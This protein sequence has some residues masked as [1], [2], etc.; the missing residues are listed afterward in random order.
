[1]TLLRTLPFVGL[2]LV[3][4]VLAHADEDNFGEDEFGGFFD[5][6]EF[7]SIATGSKKLI[8][9]APAV[10]T[11]IRADEIKA[12][13]YRTLSEALESVPGLHVS[14]SSQLYSPKIIIRGISSTF[15]PQTL[16]LVDGVPITSIV[17]GDRHAVWGDFPVNS[18]QRIEV[19]RGPGSALYGADAFSGIINI[20][21]KTADDIDNNQ[22][23]VSIGS[24]N[25]R[26]AW[27]LSK[28]I[29]GDFKLSLT[30]EFITTDGFDALIDTDIQ[31]SIDAL[32]LAPP[33]SYAPGNASLGYKGID[34]RFDVSY[35]DFDLKVG[36]QDRD[37]VGHGQGSAGALD[38]VGRFNSEKFLANLTYN[39]TKTNNWVSDIN[40]SYYRSNQKVE[41]DLLLFPPGAF[42]GAFPEG[43]IGN[44][45]WFERTSVFKSESAYTGFNKNKI[46][47]GFGYK[48]EDLY[49]VKEQKNFDAFL[50]PLGELVDVT[51]SNEV[52]IPESDRSSFFIYVQDEIQIAP[53]WELTAGIR[54]DDYS[55]F[56]STTNP[57]L[58][59]V[60]S[61]SL[62]LNTK[63]LYGRAFR[64]P[65]FAETLVVNNPIALGNP[66]LSPETI[67][68]FEVAFDYAQSNALKYHLNIYQFKV[69]DFINFV[70]DDG[71]P[72]ATAQNI[73]QLKGHGFESEINYR[74]NDDF[75]FSLNLSKQTTTDELVK[76]DLGGAPDYQ[77]YLSSMWNFYPDS[78]LNL[79]S[80]YVGKRARSSLD[81]RDDLDS[82][83]NT[84]ITYHLKNLGPFNLSF[85]I[86]NLFDSDIREPSEGPN[87]T[88]PQV[89]F[90]ND[91]PQYGRS[92]YLSIYGEI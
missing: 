18:I 83:I 76:H 69:E 54:Y 46:A 79:Y 78:S 67:D 66:N 40:L 23:G 4:I 8:S 9:K 6:E 90:P 42:F 87:N 60:W 30:G 32:E 68:T 3:L 88:S 35:L 70:P 10:A 73:G 38:P 47:L 65:A 75:R 55:D 11:L 1:M 64:A 36:F 12:M 5:D 85:S 56:G 92:Y 16:V 33:A 59:L 22:V 50:N 2:G 17:R 21:T 34:L 74:A 86:K 72:T 80:N 91:L 28:Y 43:L 89:A 71:A 26:E 15:N 77:V 53:D 13:G 20:I 31:S 48:V 58:A 24:Y 61:T 27:Y 44:P 84:G 82:Y 7:V 62:K 41:K 29:D 37:N 63:F 19:I 25:T 14:H 45:E 39:L 57:R 52:F 81:N 49:K 51:D